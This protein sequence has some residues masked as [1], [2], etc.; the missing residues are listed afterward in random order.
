MILP[1]RVERREREG[2]RERERERER[3]GEGRREHSESCARIF[4]RP[5]RSLDRSLFF[6]RRFEAAR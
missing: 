1:I 6:L 4:V 2:E 5:V 3:E